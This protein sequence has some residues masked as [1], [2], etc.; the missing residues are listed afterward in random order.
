MIE[1][2]MLYLEN[3]KVKYDGIIS[4]VDSIED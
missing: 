1:E 2:V 3:V 4:K